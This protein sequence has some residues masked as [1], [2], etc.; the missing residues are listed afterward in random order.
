MIEA[1]HAQVMQVLEVIEAAHAQLVSRPASSQG[2][3]ASKVCIDTPTG[4]H[5]LRCLHLKWQIF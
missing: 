5:V 2:G 1:A 4:A 3:C